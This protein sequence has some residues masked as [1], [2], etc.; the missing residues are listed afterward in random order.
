MGQEWTEQLLSF[1]RGQE[2][3]FEAV[4]EL[5]LSL[6]LSIMLSLILSRQVHEVLLLV[7][8]LV[9]WDDVEVVE[10]HQ[11]LEGFVVLLSRDHA[12]SVGA[13]GGQGDFFL[14]QA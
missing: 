9:A 7:V 10:F 12:S 4:H 3:F 8:L 2:L 1:H 11:T 6:A 13:R 14:A 5:V